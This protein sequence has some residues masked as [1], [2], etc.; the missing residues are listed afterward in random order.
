VLDSWRKLF[1]TATTTGQAITD[2]IPT[3]TETSPGGSFPRFRQERLLSTDINSNATHGDPHRKKT[4]GFD[5][6]CFINP[7]GISHCRDFLDFCKTLQ[8]LL[9]IDVG[10]FGLPEINLDLLK[11]EVRQR[12]GQIMQA[13]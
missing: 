8:S 10:V 2:S 9:A 1:A 11:P 13:F 12:C 3:P 7:N 4:P 6:F 5:R